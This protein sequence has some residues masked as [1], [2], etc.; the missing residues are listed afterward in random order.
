MENP[1]DW[2]WYPT[3]IA[4]MIQWHS[5]PPPSSAGPTHPPT[6]TLPTLPFP[7]EQIVAAVVTHFHTEFERIHHLINE[8]QML[9][10]KVELLTQQQ[11]DT[12]ATSVIASARASTASEIATIANEDAGRA[13]YLAETAIVTTMTA[14]DI[15]E[16][17]WNQFQ[18]AN[19]V[20]PV[21]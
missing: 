19:P 9:R 5:T 21:A 1:W 4:N 8:A 14:R 18:A 20:A 10:K 17:I 6:P 16:A 7:L 15:A 2:E 13:S 11:M 3:L 12:H